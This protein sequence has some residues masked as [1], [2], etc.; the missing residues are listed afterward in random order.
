MLTPWQR[1]RVEGAL[2]GHADMAVRG[3]VLAMAVDPKFPVPLAVP[4]EQVWS[5]QC[6]SDEPGQPP[7][8]Q[9][10]LKRRLADSPDLAEGIRRDLMPLIEPWLNTRDLSSEKDARA[11][12]K[13][14]AAWIRGLQQQGD[15]APSRWKAR[16]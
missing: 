6:R 7:V 14:A 1:E 12:D 5:A 2:D 10:Y 9:S 13:F 15:P 16:F 3:A 4:S 11:I 8:L